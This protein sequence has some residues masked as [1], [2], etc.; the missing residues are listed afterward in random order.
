MTLP[1]LYAI[2]DSSHFPHTDALC[3]SAGEL[4]AGGVTLLQYRD[5]S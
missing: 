2:L 4:A 3:Q 1:R 5:K